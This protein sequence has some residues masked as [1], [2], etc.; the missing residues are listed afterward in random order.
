MEVAG[1]LHEAA[2]V[3]VGVTE[4]VIDRQGLALGHLLLGLVLAVVHEDAVARFHPF[5][6]VGRALAAD[7]EED[8]AVGDELHVL[9][10]T[11]LCRA[12]P[13]DV[14]LAVAVEVEYQR[15]AVPPAS[16]VRNGPR[17]GVRLVPFV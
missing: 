17:H 12:E 4:E 8:R 5:D 3:A 9:L 11:Q 10:G 14:D 6:A 16:G 2:G 7:V 15:I 13:G 1:E